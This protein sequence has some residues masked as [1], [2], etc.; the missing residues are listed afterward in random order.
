[1][2]RDEVMSIATKA[3]RESGVE[4]KP[5]TF[6]DRSIFIGRHLETG[7]YNKN[8][9][10]LRRV[11]NSLFESYV[12]TDLESL[13][14][15]YQPRRGHD[16]LNNFFELFF[17]SCNALVQYTISLLS[18]YDLESKSFRTVPEILPSHILG[19]QIDAGDEE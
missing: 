10:R 4:I 15:D 18:E 8:C 16:H 12:R 11:V 1:M 17:M 6:F 2:T 13:L 5:L 7:D 14:V 9:P 3:S 19:N